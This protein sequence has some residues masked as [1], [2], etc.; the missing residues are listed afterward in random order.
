MNSCNIKHILEKYPHLKEDL[1]IRGFLVTNR[2]PVKLDEFPFC[3]KW[4]LERY[5]GYAFL[6]H[7]LTNSH[8]FEDDKGR[9]FFIFGHA[10]D[11]FAMEYEEKKILQR[12]SKAYGTPNFMERIN[13]I[14]G[15][16]VLGNR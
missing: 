6:T 2:D 10:Y 4:K 8:V 11:P 13:D 7:P 15:V 16:F 14:T 9:V 3:G 12:I 1:F 5:A